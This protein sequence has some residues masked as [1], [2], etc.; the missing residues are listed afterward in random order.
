MRKGSF[1]GDANDVRLVSG[2]SWLLLTAAGPNPR[3]AATFS[4]G[5]TKNAITHLRDVH[6]IGKDGPLAPVEEQEK[7]IRL[8]FGNTL[9]RVSFNVDIFED[10]LTRWMALCDI[11]F[12]AVEHDCFRLLLSYLASC[13]RTYIQACDTD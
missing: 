1:A 2:P 4:D 11:P 8:A 10:I 12:L 5:S 3:T 13:V 7:R 9:P 6:R